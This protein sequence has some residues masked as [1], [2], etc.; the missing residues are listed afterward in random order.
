[1]KVLQAAA[2]NKETLGIY[3][4]CA[5]CPLA[6]PSHSALVGDKYGRSSTTDWILRGA[7]A[8]VGLEPLPSAAIEPLGPAEEDEAMLTQ[9]IISGFADGCWMPGLENRQSEHISL[10]K[11]RERSQ[12][13]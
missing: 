8:Q 3:G 9:P 4:S 2:E 11:E 12:T 10:Q 7:P 5:V 13:G 6:S 1:M